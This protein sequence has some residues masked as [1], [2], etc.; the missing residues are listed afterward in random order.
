MEIDGHFARMKRRLGK[1]LFL[2]TS[3]SSAYLMRREEQASFMTTFEV[4][5][6]SSCNRYDIEKIPAYAVISASGLLKEAKSILK[7]IKNKK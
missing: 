5:G 4:I 6:E 2:R 1:N 7:Y 3:F